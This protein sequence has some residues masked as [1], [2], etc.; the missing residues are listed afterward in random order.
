MDSIDAKA[1]SATPRGGLVV[2]QGR[3]QGLAGLTPWALTVVSP[4]RSPLIAGRRQAHGSY[5]SLSDVLS[6]ELSRMAQIG[7]QEVWIEST[8]GCGLAG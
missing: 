7:R 8:M 3:R 6:P 4:R 5:S 2:R 1:A